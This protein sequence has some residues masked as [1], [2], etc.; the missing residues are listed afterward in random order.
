VWAAQPEA[1]L[2]PLLDDAMRAVA[3]LE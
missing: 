1:R 2:G 3:P